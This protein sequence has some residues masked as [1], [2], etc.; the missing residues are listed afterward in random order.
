MADR[1]ER[2]QRNF[3]WGRSTNVF[4]YSL[5]A[6]EKVVW[7]VEA[8]GLGIQRTGLFNQALL[9]KWRF[10]KEPTHLW[11][12]VIASKYGEGSGGWCTRAIRGTHGYGMWKNIRKEAKS[13]FGHVLYATGEGSHT[14]F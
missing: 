10:G 12:Q 4:K 1:L 2:I 13:F 14:R 11:L 3:L 8:G 5:V 7:L 6:W 9:G